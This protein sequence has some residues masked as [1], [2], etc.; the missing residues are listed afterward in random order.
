MAFRLWLKISKLYVA[1]SVASERIT[2]A[3]KDHHR[4]HPK[5]PTARGS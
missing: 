2:E 1:L 3:L 4:T 5:E